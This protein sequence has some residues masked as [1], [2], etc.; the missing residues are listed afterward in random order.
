ML[1]IT[2][3][4]IIWARV[5]YMRQAVGWLWPSRTTRL[6]A[7]VVSFKVRPLWL[8]IM[9]TQIFWPLINDVREN[10]RATRWPEANLHAVLAFL[11]VVYW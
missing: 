3:E 7:L 1:G 11:Q 5:L 4:I 6:D 2:I 10:R 8:W 9:T